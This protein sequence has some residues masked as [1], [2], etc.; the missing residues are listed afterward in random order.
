MMRRIL[1]IFLKFRGKLIQRKRIV[2]LSS[3]P[4]TVLVYLKNAGD[5]NHPGVTG[6]ADPYVLVTGN[7]SSFGTQ[8]TTSLY[9]TGY[10]NA[11]GNRAV[12]NEQ[13]MVCHVT[14]NDSVVLTL[15][16]HDHHMITGHDFLGQVVIPLSAYPRL[17]A[18][19]EL[20]VSLPIGNF[21][22]PIFDCMGKPIKLNKTG[23]AGKGMITFS[24]RLSPPGLSHSGWIMKKAGGLGAGGFKRRFM[25][26]VDGAL[27][28]FDDNGSL[29]SPRHLL[30]PVEIEAVG[31]GVE[32]GVQVVTITTP[33]PRDSW[34]LQWV[35]GESTENKEKWMSKLTRFS[36]MKQ[37]LSRTG[38]DSSLMS[39]NSLSSASSTTKRKKRLSSIFRHQK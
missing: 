11:P 25:V 19:R 23:T 21:V 15:V 35:E 1:R 8:H 7:T 10:K 2:E 28:Y 20:N 31:V 13:A 17:F 32:K 12:W 33:D 5:I 14:G 37:R 27:M 26:L 22:N 9:K 36:Q 39:S 3:S 34:T 6:V 16:N 18:R 30:T 24:I 38:S 29:D 4:H